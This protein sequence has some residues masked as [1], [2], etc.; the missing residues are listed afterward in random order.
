MFD[1]I[2]DF[3]DYRRQ[4]KPIQGKPIALNLRANS[5]ASIARHLGRILRILTVLQNPNLAEDAKSDLEK[6][7]NMRK[8]ALAVIGTVLP[9]NVYD[10]EKMYNDTVHPKPEVSDNG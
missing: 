3:L 5:P 8:A 10:I 4:I 2:K 7:F 1:L 6:E 9:D